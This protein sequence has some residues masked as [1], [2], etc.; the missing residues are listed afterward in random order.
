MQARRHA[1]VPIEPQTGC[2]GGKD[3]SGRCNPALPPTVQPRLQ[4]YRESLLPSQGHAPQ[5]RRANRQQAVGPD[6]QARRYLLARRMGKLLQVLQLRTG[7]NGKRF[8]L[9]YLT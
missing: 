6:W 4:P 3:R 9:V 5:G 8:S 2:G 1:I 7:M